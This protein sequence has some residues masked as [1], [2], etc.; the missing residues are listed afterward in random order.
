MDYDLKVKIIR[1]VAYKDGEDWSC[2]S[3]SHSCNILGFVMGGDGFVQVGDVITALRA[4]HV[5][6]IPL[7]TL[8][9]CWSDT[10]IDV[11]HVEFNVEV[12]TGQDA[13]S[14]L[15]H[16]ME[17][18]YPLDLMQAIS[19]KNITVLQERLWFHGELEKAVSLFIDINQL[20][21]NSGML[22]FK[23]ILDDIEQNLNAD[24]RLT[25]IARK[26][27]WHPSVLSRKFSQ[28]FRFGLKN[29]IDLMLINK[30][31]QELVNSEKSLKTLADEYRFC[32]AFYL[33][34]FFK[35]HEGIS[36]DRF[37]RQSAAASE[38]SR[39]DFQI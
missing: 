21:A 18:P 1:S 33:S 19:Q 8:Y 29:Y 23:P 25:D 26:H 22:K 4:A 6:L 24:L 31:K 30:I 36:P 20:P 10:F 15:R 7:N 2:E 11:F 38:A 35:K 32:D 34:A 5:Y 28:T 3:R 14:G 16:I 17:L 13:F 27:G 9:S 12:V 39:T 37:R